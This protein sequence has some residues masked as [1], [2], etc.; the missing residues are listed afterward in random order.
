ME[1]WRTTPTPPAPLPSGHADREDKNRMSALDDT[2]ST[3]AIDELDVEI[4]DFVEFMRIYI[5]RTDSAFAETLMNDA[6]ELLP[7]SSYNPRIGDSPPG[8]PFQ[9]G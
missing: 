2:D 7:S 4:N 6:S 3:A 5:T 8:P 1:T 9:R